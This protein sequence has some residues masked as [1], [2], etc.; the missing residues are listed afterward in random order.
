MQ[1]IV[2]SD[3]HGNLTALNAVLDNIHE[4]YEPDAIAILGD[5]ID[6][7]MRSNEVIERVKAIQIPIVCNIWGNHE[8]AIMLNDYTRFSSQ[9][10]VD[11]AKNTAKKLSDESKMYLSS[12]N[13]KD[14]QK[15]FTW[16][17]LKFLAIHGSLEDAFWKSITPEGSHA[18]YEEYDY[19][20]SGHSHLPHI[21][22]VY[23]KSDNA[24]LRNKKKTIFINPGS[25]GQPRNQNPKA[26]YAVIDTVKGIFLNSV[27][28][29]I[30]LEQ[31]FFDSSVDQFYKERLTLGV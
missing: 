30:A 14:G 10:G 9:R 22:P 16:N 13:G 28:Y 5:F 31:S 12:L 25:V 23:Y 20:L 3:I 24:A 7:G 6:Y 29:D 18:G 2:L 1:L 26:Q 15:Q 21:F 19:V 27:E 17:G 8:R 4:H 11:S